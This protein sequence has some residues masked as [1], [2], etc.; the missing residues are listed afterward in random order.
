MFRSCCFLR[1]AIIATAAIASLLSVACASPLP[2]SGATGVLF[3]D[4]NNA[5]AEIAAI[6]T[7]LPSLDSQ[8]VVLPSTERI[9]ASRRLQILAVQ[10]RLGAATLQA[11]DCVHDSGPRNCH[12]VWS[13]MRALELERLRL[14]GNYGID[15]LTAD[16]QR[17]VIDAGVTINMVILSGHHSGGYFGGELA[18]LDAIDL[19]TLDVLFPA[20]FG[21]VRSVLLLGCE[22]GTPRLLQDVF[23]PLFPSARVIVGAEDYA[24]TRD[25]GRNL[26]FIRAVM[27]HQP[28]LMQAHSAGTAAR[29]HNLLLKQ[30]WPVAM[31][32]DREH[33]FA[34]D[35]YQRLV[36]AMPLARVAHYAQ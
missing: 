15:E 23:A 22:T 32:W 6:R 13:D 30:S 36:A 35:I 1:R 14:G 20:L 7:S 16:I 31:L 3:I 11:L 34:R 21:N 27:R 33:Y 8:L 26:R 24:P 19:R 18:R 2:A 28:A 4:L 25:E 9:P 12:A 5:T 10:R 29:I 17:H